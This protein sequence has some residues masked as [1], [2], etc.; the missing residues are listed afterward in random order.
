MGMVENTQEILAAARAF[1]RSA[2]SLAFEDFWR[3]LRGASLIPARNVFNP[4]RAARFIRDLVLME[5]PHPGGEG[6]RIR[7]AGERYQE[8]AGQS[9]GGVDHL[10]FLAPEYR[11]GARMTG[12]LMASL[13]CGLWQ[14]APL[15]NARGYGQLIE[16]TAFPL[17]AGDDGIP[18]LLCHVGLMDILVQGALPTA[19][20]L[21]LDT[22]TQ[23]R[24]LDI[25]AGVPE[26]TED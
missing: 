16:V 13:P 3:A 7:I 15:H 19:R 21:A 5:A 18:L 17:G 10:E 2:Q 22:A 12:E 24:F 4:A 1:T 6:M 23:F 11:E 9:L 8:I 25:G 14:I 20:G 26:L